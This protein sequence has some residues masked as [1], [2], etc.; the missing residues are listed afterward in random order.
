MPI[1]S[2]PENVG[3]SS[4]FKRAGGSYTTFTGRDSREAVLWKGHRTKTKSELG[5]T[6]LAKNGRRRRLRKEV[7][8]CKL[9]GIFCCLKRGKNDSKRPFLL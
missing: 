2:Y 4:S 1:S 8:E 3:Q 7:K 6:K 9:K 5:P